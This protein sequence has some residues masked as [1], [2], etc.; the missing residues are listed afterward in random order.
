[1]L[2]LELLRGDTLKKLIALIIILISLFGGF[3]IYQKMSN[4]DNSDVFVTITFDID[5]EKIVKEVLRGESVEAPIVPSKEGYTFVGWDNTA[6]FDLLTKDQTYKAVYEINQYTISFNTKCDY[7]VED[8]KYEYGDPIEDFDIPVRNGYEFVG[9]YYQGVLFEKSTMP[10]YDVELDAVWYSTIT[11]SDVDGITFEPLKGIAGE[12]ISA[13]TIKE[14]NKRPGETIVWYKDYLYQ[15]QYTFNRMPEDNI[16]LYGRFEEIKVVDP[17]FLD[18]LVN[19]ELSNI[20]ESYDDLVDYLEYLVYHQITAPTAIVIEFDVD[21]AQTILNKAIDDIEIDTYVRFT[22]SRKGNVYTIKLEFEEEATQKASL[23]NLYQQLECAENHSASNRTDTFNDFAID[24]L[25]KTYK[26]TTSEQLYYIVERGYKPEFESETNGISDVRKIYEEARYILRNIIDDDM[27]E[28]EKV[29]AI[30]D[31]L[32]LNVTYDKRLKD[33]VLGNIQDVRKYRGFYLEGVF[34]DKRAVCDGI[35]KAFVLMCRIEGIEAIRVT[36]VAVDGSYNHAWNKVRIDN[37]W[38]IVDAT[39]GG[40]IVENNEIMNHKYLFTNEDFFGSMFVATTYTDVIAYGE[41][42]IYEELYFVYDGYKYD[43]N[44]TSQNELNMII[45]WY[46]TN[47]YENT[48]I[49]MRIDFDYGESLEDELKIAMA[50][51]N[52]DYLVPVITDNDILIIKEFKLK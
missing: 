41:Y 7:V 37:M 17:G 2:K 9:W 50:D 5:G 38:Y 12:S 32:V 49:D 45:K 20:I 35:S 28:Y 47:Y 29:H 6:S 4:G 31:W 52:L 44:I 3:F 46:I 1:M 22:G 30:Y 18:N 40:T 33:Y 16:I 13:P 26:V 23:T 27:D 48:T 19:N 25:T 8:I 14:E 15:E 36:G 24:S 43:Y 42:N 10:A 39:S 11:F 34:L 21:N 51:T